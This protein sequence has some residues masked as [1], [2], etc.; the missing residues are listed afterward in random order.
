MR[1][2]CFEVLCKLLNS[3]KYGTSCSWKFICT[4]TSNKVQVLFMVEGYIS[5]KH[6]VI[7]SLELWLYL[8]LATWWRLTF[9]SFGFNERCILSSTWHTIAEDRCH[10]MMQSHWC[11]PNFS[12]HVLVV[13]WREDVFHASKVNTRH[14]YIII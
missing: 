4:G 11:N 5:A 10:F 14:V 2:F 1:R 7:W 6:Y 3:A 9:T 8:S 12:C 13:K